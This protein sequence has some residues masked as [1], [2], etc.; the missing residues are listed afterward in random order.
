[1]SLAYLKTI[2]FGTD[3]T[4]TLATVATLRPVS[5]PTVARVA[6]V[7][8]AQFADESMQTAARAI[9]MAAMKDE[10]KAARLAHLR[11][12]PALAK[13]WALVFPEANTKKETP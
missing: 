13:F 8:V 9:A 1:M 6:T 3:A 12:E 7:T 5:T 2:S 11:R 10:K 4:A